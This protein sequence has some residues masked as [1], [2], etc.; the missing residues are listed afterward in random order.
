MRHRRPP[1]SAWQRTRVVAGVVALALALAGLAAGVGSHLIWNRT[2]SMPIGLYWLDRGRRTL[3]RNALVAFPI[4]DAVRGLV[5]ERR[6][7]PD[8]AVILKQIVALP[9]DHVC[10]WGGAFIVNGV[11][12]GRVLDR[13][14]AGRRLPQLT[15][16]GAVGPGDVF[17]A[18]NHPRSFDSRFFGPVAISA[19]K[20]TVTLLWTP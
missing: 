19:V 6:Y 4:P 14:A 11:A 12:L 17:V 10:I 8:D 16:C 20:G 18:S 15:L 7:L 5:H 9:G 3:V 1:N 13:D 2:P